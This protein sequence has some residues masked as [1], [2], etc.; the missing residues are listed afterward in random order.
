MKKRRRIEITTFRRRTTIFFRD[1]SEVG[2]PH[3]NG[4]ASHPERGDL[5]RVKEI[6][7]D[8]SKHGPDAG[9]LDLS[10]DTNDRKLT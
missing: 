10:R 9:N 2:R 8:S 5:E 3:D 1:T 4:E 6:N 7:L